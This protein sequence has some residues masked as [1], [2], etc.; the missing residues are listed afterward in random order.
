MFIKLRYLAIIFSC[1]GGSAHAL[2]LL[3]AYDQARRYDADYKT[4]VSNYQAA[5]L[6]LPLAQSAN[7]LSITT[8]LNLRHVGDRGATTRNYES[9]EWSLDLGQHLYNRSTHYD[10][11]SAGYAVAIAELELGMAKETLIV[12]TVA[13]Y[14]NVL[15]ALD[16]ENLAELE[17]AAIEKQLDLATQRLEVGLGTKT[18][19]YDA[20]ARF[21]AASAELIAAKNEVI[22]TQQALEAL[23]GQLF[24]THPKDL[25]QTLDNDKVILDLVEGNEWVARVLQ[26]NRSY[27]IKLRQIKLQEVEVARSVDARIPTVELFADVSASDS[28]SADG[29]RQGWTVGVRGSMP[30]YLGGAIKLR[31]EK[32]GYAFN[33]ASH[34]AAQ[35]RRDTDRLIRAARR[36]VQS[37][38]RQVE[39]RKQAVI[40]GKSALEAKEEEFKAGV[41]TNLIVL[42]AQRD[43]FRSRRDYLRASYD[44]VNAIVLLERSAGELDDEDV[45]KI[46][47]WLK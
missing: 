46:N 18:D 47:S 6:D 11:D 32:A 37:L 38:Q 39:A 16:N 23:M 1:F 40:A 2:N 21:E 19:Q 26:R 28:N 12:D 36:D 44:L 29:D 45:S 22:N 17:R 10:I 9:G 27:Q 5:Q 33:A 15:S 30:L 3:E 13:N 20:Q 41:T 43:L 24:A 35:S 34:E 7:R 42:D 14:L 25:M 8:N 31:Q 4:A